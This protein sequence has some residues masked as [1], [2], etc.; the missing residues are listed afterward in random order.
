MFLPWGNVE[1]G[2]GQVNFY[3]ILHKREKIVVYFQIIHE[4]LFE[5]TL[6]LLMGDGDK[7]DSMLYSL[8]DLCIECDMNILSYE[9]LKTLII[10][11]QV[12]RPKQ[13]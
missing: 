12:T 11:F 5:Q 3:S 10:L 8:I 9:K 6:S 4:N 7:N 13:A 1:H 2:L